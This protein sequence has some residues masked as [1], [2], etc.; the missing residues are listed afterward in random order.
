[1]AEKSE[2]NGRLR[3]RDY[4]YFRRLWNNVVVALLAVSFAPL[5]LVG[6]GMYYYAASALKKETLESLRSEVSAHKNNIDSFISERIYSLRLA[7]R[8]LSLLDTND[9]D[10]L[11]AALT[12]L[13]AEMGYFVD[14][15]LIDGLGRHLA[16]H[17]PYD[18]KNRNYKEAFW[19]QEA[20]DRE[21]YISDVYL[22]FRKVP[23]FIMTL[24]L[25]K[26]SGPVILRATIDA[27][28]FNEMVAGVTGRREGDS[29]LLNAEGV[30]Q[31]QPRNIGSLMEQ[32]GIK[33]IEPFEGVRVDERAGEIIAEVWLDKV[34]WLSVV[35]ISR[36]DIF[37][38]LNRV[39]NAGILIFLLGSIIIVF[40]VLLTTNYLVSRLEYKR[41]SI[42]ALD[43]ELRRTS[44]MAS[45]LILS[46]RLLTELK[47]S[48]AN[49]DASLAVIRDRAAG[50]GNPAAISEN[51]DHIKEELDRNRHMIDRFM[52]ATR[53]PSPVPIITDIGLNELLDDLLDLLGSEFRHRNIRI[54]RQYQTDLPAIRNDSGQIRLIFQNLLLNALAAVRLDGV[55]V[56]STESGQ[57]RIQITIGHNG[58]PYQVE[59]IEELS[60]PLFT[61]DQDGVNLGLAFSASALRKLGGSMTVRNDPG[62]GAFLH[63]EIG[64]R[65]KVTGD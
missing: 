19:F 41:K 26:P 38:K 40:T 56:L 6:G 29:Y 2:Q 46:N 62:R 43:S 10:R 42:R 15:G 28:P 47:T 3:S 39:R 36:A 61:A 11:E 65:L 25:E 30:F 8:T 7:A 59:E 9:T 24:R 27:A 21:V 32:S 13:H 17:G 1:M 14:L 23:H 16:Y 4:P 48:M 31:S 64:L 60:E 45:S 33:G 22:G 37:A 5:F 55:I 63:V 12:E 49:A 54:D 57:D 35:Q 52:A 51:I 34:H 20:F 50:K 58:S 53:P 18:L 44:Q